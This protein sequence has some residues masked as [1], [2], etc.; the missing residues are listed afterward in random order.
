M[1][2]TICIEVSSMH[3]RAAGKT[4]TLKQGGA[5]RVCTQWTVSV[6]ALG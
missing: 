4:N 1:D 6:G 3:V 2:V 5:I